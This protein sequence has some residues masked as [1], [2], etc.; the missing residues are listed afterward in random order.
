MDLRPL[1]NPKSIAIVGASRE[2]TK[3]GNVIYRNCTAFGYRG[4]VF[5]VNPKAKRIEGKR[6]YP[7]LQALPQRVDL[8]IVVTPAAVV[9]VVIADA[10]RA[11]ARSAIVISAGFGE[12]G[13]QGK[14]LE[15]KVA[16]IAKR[17]RLPLLGPNCL[18]IVL[19]HLK[20]NASF[21]QGMPLAGSVS[22]L[23][24]SGAIAVADM[25]WAAGRHLGFR[26]VV[27]LG[28][29]A[30]LNASDLLE[31]I[32][33]D[34]GTKVILFYLEDLREGRRFLETAQRVAATKPIIILR[35]GRSDAAAKAAQSHTGALAGSSAVT[36]ALLQQAGCI[37][38]TT[39]E[40]WFAFAVACSNALRPK[41]NRLGILTN[42]GGPGILATDAIAGT[43]LTLATLTPKTT[44]TLQRVLPPAAAVHNPVDVIGDAPPARYAK[45]LQVLTADANVDVVVSI[46]T[47]QLTTRSAAVAKAIITETRRTK[48]PIL[49]SFVGGPNVAKA[50][51]TLRKAGVPAFDYPELAIRAA[52]ALVAGTRSSGLPIRPLLKPSNSLRDTSVVVGERARKVLGTGGIIVL[53]SYVVKSSAQA[54]KVAERLHYP[55]VM[56]LDSPKIVHKTDQHAVLTDLHTPKMVKVAFKRFQRTFARLLKKGDGH[57]ILQDQRSN[58]VEVFLGGLQDPQFGP[59]VLVGFG[60]IYVEA[61]RSTSYACAPLTTTDA[62]TLLERTALWRILSGSRGH[63]FNVDA[64]ALLVSK[65]S[66]FLAEHPEVKAIDC[67]P[68]LVTHL[69]ATILD[70]RLTFGSA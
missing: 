31:A 56:K 13:K 62:R 55:V 3:L 33:A 32:D 64:L 27:S 59:V 7:N 45:G 46:L 61:I 18:G 57:I 60:G 19:P 10:V 17:G 39:I 41:G 65:L 23:S 40:D 1:L 15:E 48:K 54:V 21:G 58:G 16:V 25:D 28:N 51:A 14:A 35:A 12:T 70:A 34:P 11:K 67:N 5:A 50:V 38:V 6:A 9:P 37:T 53:P 24:Q 8:V 49:V 22:I 36:D 69:G 42:A 63:T 4:K 52:N 43:A 29:K 30:V 20:L 68:V 2:R 26:S 66:R 44:S 47:D